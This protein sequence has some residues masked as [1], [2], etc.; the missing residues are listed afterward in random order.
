MFMKKI[1][2][3]LIALAIAGMQACTKDKTNSG[4]DNNLFD[5]ISRGGYVYYRNGEILNPVAPSPHG[6]FRLRFDSVAASALDSDG[7]LMAGGSFPNG[8][9]LVKEVMNGSSVRLLVVMKKSSNDPNSKR[10]WVWAELN[11]DGSAEYSV[12]YK[13]SSCISC[14]SETPNRDLTRTFDL[15]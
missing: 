11:T 14:H 15:H 13:G 4:A 7:E 5:E 9:V 10:G 6:A 12:V 8:S 3:F 2:L 1:F